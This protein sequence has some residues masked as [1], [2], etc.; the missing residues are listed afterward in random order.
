MNKSHRK[1][2]YDENREDMRE[3]HVQKFIIRLHVYIIDMTT[4]PH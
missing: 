3:T 1:E 2:K 4:N